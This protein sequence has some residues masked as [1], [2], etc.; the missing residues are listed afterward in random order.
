[1]DLELL[2]Y[3]SGLGVGGVIAAFA[4]SYARKDSLDFQ[5]AW[6]QQSEAWKGQTAILVDLVQE[7]AKALATHTTMIGAALA[8]LER[9]EHSHRR[10]ER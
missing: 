8:R 2:K 3:L 7:T 10:D 5:K 6:Q 9:A 4:L 1:M